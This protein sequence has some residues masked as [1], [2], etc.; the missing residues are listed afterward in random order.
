[1]SQPEGPHLETLNVAIGHGA[2]NS[3][4]MFPQLSTLLLSDFTTYVLGAA[5]DRAPQKDWSEL[6]PVD[7][8]GALFSL[9]QDVTEEDDRQRAE[10]W[11]KDA[12]GI[13]VFVRTSVSFSTPL[14][15]SNQCYR[16]VCCLSPLSHY[17]R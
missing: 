1:M 15:A 9:Y 7:S 14:H 6:E 8:S 11:Q 13:L 3:Q 5:T 12:D 4:C 17:L 16:L 10:R 2:E